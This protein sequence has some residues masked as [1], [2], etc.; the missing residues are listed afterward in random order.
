M[1]HGYRTN[2]IS[3]A[4]LK[5]ISK[6][7][8]LDYGEMENSPASAFAH[9]YKDPG[10]S[11]RDDKFDVKALLKIGFLHC[12]HYSEETQIGDFWILLNPKLEE[13]VTLDTVK[14]FIEGLIHVS[15]ETP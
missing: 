12:R 10:F 6:Q 14:A 11:L 1:R 13:T 3:T 8:G 9:F 15:V 5:S 2:L 7:I 4:H